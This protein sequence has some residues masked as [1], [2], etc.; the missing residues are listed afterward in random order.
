[1]MT[2][3]IADM[4]TRIRNAQAAGLEKVE[5][6]ASKMLESIA[7]I[8]KQEGY[9]AAAKSYNHKGRRYLRL[10]LRYEDGA[11][12]IREIRRVSKPGRRVYAGADELPRVKGGYGIAIVST[13]HGVMADKKARRSHIGGEIICTVF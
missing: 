11:P 2:D 10:G 6:P 8:L 12:V 13:S 4:L 3:R 1:M 7:E 9:I 5:M